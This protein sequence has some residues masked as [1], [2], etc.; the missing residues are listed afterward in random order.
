MAAGIA[1]GFEWRIVIPQR[2]SR[3]VSGIAN[4]SI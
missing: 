3:G 4:R 1:N 2:S